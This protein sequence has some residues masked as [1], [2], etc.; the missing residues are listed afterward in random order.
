MVRPL[1]TATK[2]ALDRPVVPLAAIVYLDILGDPLFAWTG[3]GDLTFAAAETG[4][5]GLDNKTFKGV[6]SVIEV[7]GIEEGAGGSDSLEI[8]FPGVDPD[9]QLM[10]QI[11]KDRRR[12]QFRRAIVWMLVLNPD[13]MA[14]EG[15]PFRIKTGR[16]DAMPYSESNDKAGF[17]CVIEGQQSY[18]SEPLNTR[19]SEQIDIDS[20]DTSQKWVY[21]LAN[22]SAKIGTKSANAT[23]AAA[24]MA[25]SGGLSWLLNGPNVGG[26][27]G[28]IQ[29]ALQNR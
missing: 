22:M 7:S 4:D 2:D 20:T 23:R 18:G 19:Y 1:Q 25:P 6:G 15:K 29:R 26:F 5:S 12:W 11:I 9:S 14:I 17:K 16:M 21:A 28:L 13:T 8:T 24:G 3:I 27:L 10:K